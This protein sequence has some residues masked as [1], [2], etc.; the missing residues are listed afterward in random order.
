MEDGNESDNEVVVTDMV[1]RFLVRVF[2]L[3]L[4]TVGGAHNL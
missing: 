1:G 3:D 4:S 2:N